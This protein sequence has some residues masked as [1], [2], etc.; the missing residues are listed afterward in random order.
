M[1]QLVGN[2]KPW[3]VKLPV[4]TAM[5]ELVGRAV[6]RSWQPRLLEPPAAGAAWPASGWELESVTLGLWK[7][8]MGRLL[9]LVLVVPVT[10]TP[11]LTT[12]ALEGPAQLP[13]M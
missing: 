7:V 8:M 9:V 5:A 4:S 2:A 12:L 6:S 1:T 11:P 10:L 3:E 13:R